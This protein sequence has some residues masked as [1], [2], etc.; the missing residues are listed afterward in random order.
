MIV[1]AV[2]PALLLV[3][4][5]IVGSAPIATATVAGFFALV[6]AFG[7]QLARPP[8]LRHAP[9]LAVRVIGGVF[10]AGSLA[11]AVWMISK[12]WV[13]SIGLSAL[14]LWVGA[15]LLLPPRALNSAF[16]ASLLPVSVLAVAIQIGVVVVQ[17]EPFSWARFVW[18]EQP[19]LGL[20]WWLLAYASAFEAQLVAHE[21]GHLTAARRAGLHILGVRAGLLRLERGTNGRLLPTLNRGPAAMFHGRVEY[22]ADPPPSPS[23]Q[24]RIAFAGPAVDIAIA[25]LGGILRGFEGGALESLGTVL[26]CVGLPTAVLNLLPLNVL[27]PNGRWLPLD[28]AQLLAGWRARARKRRQATFP[29]SHSGAQAEK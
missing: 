3:Y 14:L 21:L 17:G 15:L 16:F 8:S 24:I 9:V 23:D 26:L 11:L 20:A 27:D 12:G 4:A 18:L 22:L 1:I 7:F 29:R 10:F 13:W 6:A 2:P 5:S 19:E 25:L 28:G